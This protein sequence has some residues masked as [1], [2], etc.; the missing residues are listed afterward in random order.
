MT[1]KA[2]TELLAVH[3]G[4]DLVTSVF[5]E[6]ARVSNVPS[7]TT[8]DSETAS[9]DRLFKSRAARRYDVLGAASQ[10][11]FRCFTDSESFRRYVAVEVLA[12]GPDA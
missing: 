9:A 4:G 3:P 1:N 2:Q 5:N 12:G 7:H 8:I 11:G 10:A 6:I